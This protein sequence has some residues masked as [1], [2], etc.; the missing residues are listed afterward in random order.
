VGVKKTERGFDL[1][2]FKDFDEVKCS[3]QK[4]SLATE[5]AIWF[6][7]SKGNPKVLIPGEGWKPI[8]LPTGDVVM[9]T[10]MHLTRNMA[11]KLLPYLQTFVETG[12][13]RRGSR[14]KVRG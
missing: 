12:E 5:D 1:V 11:K 2:E 13:L 3:L 6:G 7:C 14:Y 10:R 8:D 4:S 9:N